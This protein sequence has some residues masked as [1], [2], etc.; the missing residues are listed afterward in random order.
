MMRT[1]SIVAARLALAA[2][3]AAAL[4]LGAFA[5]APAAGIGAASDPAGRS[6]EP[7]RLILPTGTTFDDLVRQGLLDDPRTAGGRDLPTATD[8]DPGAAP[9]GDYMGW[10]AYTRDGARLL[11]TNRGTNNVTVYDAT[12]RAVLANIPVGTYPAGLACSDEYAVIACAFSNEVWIVDLDDYSAAAVIPVS[13][14]PWV[15]R[16]SPDQSRA[17]VSCDIPD[18]CEVIDLGTLDL[19]ASITPFPIWLSTYTWGSENGRNSVNFSEFEVT[20]DGQHL[21]TPDGESM[22]LFINTQTGAVDYSV[23]IPDP[24]AVALSGDGLKAVAV[25]LENPGKAYR[26]DLATHAVTASVALP[27]GYT[28]ST[29][30]AG[31]NQDGSKAFLGVTDNSS[32]FVNFNAGTSRILASTYTPFWIETSP[33]HS[34]ALGIQFRFSVLDFATETLIGQTE[35]NSQNYGAASPTAARAIGY[36]PIRNEGIYFY[37]YINPAAPHYLGQTPAGVE[38]EA[39]CPRRVTITPDGRRAVITNVLSGNAVLLNLETL[40]VEATFPISPRPQDVAITSDSRWAVVCAMENNEVD[41]IDLEAGAIVASVP[42]NTRPSLLSILPDDSRAM[43]ATIQGNTVSVVRLAGAAS[44][45]EA[46]IPVG[47]IGLTWAGYGVGSDVQCSPAGR[48]TICAISFENTVKVIDRNT[49]TVVATLPTGTFPLQAAFEA[50]GEYATVT[51]YQGNSFTVL[52]VTGAG[53]SV[54][55]N[56]PCGQ[57]PLRVGYDPVHDRMGIANL[58][59]KTITFANPRTGAI[60][61]T[62]NVTSHG[63]PLQVLFDASGDPLVLTTS[64]HRLVYNGGTVTLPATPAQFDYS[65]SSRQA[66]VAM[67]GPDWVTVVSFPTSGVPEVATVPLRG[68]TILSI[69]PNPGSGPLRVEYALAGPAS[70]GVRLIDASG[71]RV[72]ASAAERVKGG[73]GTATIEASGLAAGTYFAVLEIDGRVADSRRVVV[74][75]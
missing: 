43:V 37:E 21:I 52:R 8:L 25:T 11:L 61:G 39:D 44:F 47:E 58:S 50:T 64:N 12:T 6:P 46:D 75:P 10:A 35:G 5:P 63:S 41:I 4:S 69:G 2:V 67:P 62:Q 70:V 59:S 71:R 3:A 15:V 19:A 22:V 55:G 38:P 65:P 23:P 7:M 9:E 18:V 49:N 48:Y 34:L 56:F 29:F 30:D 54:V 73:R 72:A 68:G 20:P 66:V 16:I 42:T 36:D 74:A 33:D 53:S 27:A 28:I 32:A 26:I 17:Y 57:G 60:L 40:A 1:H 31:V 14:Q 51:N 45:R 13:E 24:V